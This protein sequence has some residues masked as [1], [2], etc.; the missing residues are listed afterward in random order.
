MSFPEKFQDLLKEWAPA[1]VIP[2]SLYVAYKLLNR[3]IPGAHNLPKLDVKNK[4]VVITGAS[5]GLGKSLAFELYKRGAQVILLARS[6]DKLK[7]ICEELKETFPLNQ[8]EPT[9]YYFDITDPEQAPWAEIPRVDILINNAGMANRGSCADTSM[10]IH[11]QAMETNYFGH[12]HVTNSLLS[13]LS[14]DGC[15]VVTSSVQGKVAI[16]YRGS[17][18]AS[19]HALQAYFDCLRAEHKNLHILV[20]SAGYINTGFGSRAIDPSGKVVGVEDE[21]QKKG[22]TPEHCARLIVNAIRDRKTDYIMAH[23]DARFAVFLRYFW[24]TLLNYSLYI[25]GTKDQ[26]APKN[27]KE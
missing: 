3:I 24:P 4:V 16:P 8:N 19:K 6:T 27:K 17:Y 5:S 18:G 9:Y 1:L 20:V 15:I 23:A 26:W 14:P 12:V 22:Y 2:L 10:A 25:R 13:K 11:R 21:N 7:E